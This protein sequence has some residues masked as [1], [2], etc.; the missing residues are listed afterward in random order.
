MQMYKKRLYL[1]IGFDIK[2]I[3]IQQSQRIKSNKN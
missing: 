1:K 3:K 2:D